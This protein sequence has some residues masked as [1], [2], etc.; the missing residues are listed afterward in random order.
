MASFMLVIGIGNDYRNDD[1][2]GLAVSRKLHSR[3]IPYIQVVEYAGN[4]LSLIEAWQNASHVFVIDAVSSG[5]SPG[6][7]YRFDA[8]VQP[9]PTSC[10]FHSTH[11]L[12][13]AESIELARA[14]DQLPSHFIVYAIEGKDFS[15]GTGL[16]QK[17][18]SAVD[19][20]VER[21]LIEGQSL[22]P[23]VYHL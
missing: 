6:T 20:V 15:T 9:L 17:V 19:E 11:A 23:F 1:G 14:L 21:L 12:G 4:G 2:A 22:D 8:A 5:A 18:E 10:M 3:G 7:I 16:S 13:L